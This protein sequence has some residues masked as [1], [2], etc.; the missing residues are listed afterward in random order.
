MIDYYSPMPLFLLNYKETCPNRYS[1]GT[2]DYIGLDRLSDNA[3]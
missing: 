2:K 1:F 3:G